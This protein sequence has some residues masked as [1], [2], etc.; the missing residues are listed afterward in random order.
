MCREERMEFIHYE[1]LW[2]VRAFTGLL[3][4]GIGFCTIWASFNLSKILFLI[5]GIIFA[6]IQRVH[7]IDRSNLTATTYLGFGIPITVDWWSLPIT[8]RK[9]SIVG[10]INVNIKELES[11]EGDK[12]YRVI[13]VSEGGS[14]NLSTFGSYDDARDKSDEIISLLGLYENYFGWHN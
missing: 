14:I 12:G 4:S 9:Y 11:L 8:L 7:V 6:S 13:L 10:R 3:L 2:W 1:R 5:G